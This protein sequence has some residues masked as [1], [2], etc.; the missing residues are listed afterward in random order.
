VN[1]VENW[2]GTFI[3]WVF[4]HLIEAPFNIVTAL[5]NPSLWLGWVPYA[6]FS[7]RIGDKEAGESLLRFIYY[8]ASWELFFAIL[9][10]FIVYTVI[11]M[12]RKSLLWATVRGLEAFGNGV[13][14]L[15]AWAGLLMVLQQ[16]MIVFMQRIFTVAE[17][18]VG[19]GTSFS[20]GVTWWAEERLVL[21]MASLSDTEAFGL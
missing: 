14:R 8:G 5:M 10:F 4:A 9:F 13:G 16:I 12:F 11:G 1:L 7:G 17:I 18:S 2:G 15:F 20:A 3:G 21:L 19:F 6:S